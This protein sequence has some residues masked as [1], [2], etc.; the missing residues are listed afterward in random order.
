MIPVAIT[1]A[2]YPGNRSAAAFKIKLLDLG[3]LVINRVRL[4]VAPFAVKFKPE[5]GIAAFLVENPLA[6]RQRWIVSHVLA[7]TAF[8]NGPPVAFVVF[9]KVSDLLLHRCSV[10]SRCSFCDPKRAATNE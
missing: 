9:L 5:A 7:M 2:K 10:R 3:G 1:N 4:F 8:Q 6:R